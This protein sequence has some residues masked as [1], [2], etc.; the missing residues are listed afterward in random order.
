VVEVSQFAATFCVA[1]F[2]GAALYINLVEH[3]ARLTLDTASAAAQWAPSYHRATLM[4]APLAV[5]S[6]LAGLA[7][8]LLG[9]GR[10]WLVSASLIGAV[11]PFTLIGIMP[12]NRKLLAHGRDLRSPDT[13]RLLEKWGTLHSV[14]TVLSAA[15]FLLM[16]SQLVRG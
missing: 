6:F 4:Q 13:R 10:M 7:A 12:T 11:V 9:A 14:R 3:P 16:L 2:A 5:L 15:A 8:W 1:L